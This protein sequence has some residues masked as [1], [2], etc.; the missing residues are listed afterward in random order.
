MPHK[1]IRTHSATLKV[2]IE[3]IT[4]KLETKLDPDEISY[5]QGAQGSMAYVEGWRMFN[6]A[7]KYLDSMVGVQKY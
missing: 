2:N 3:A 4:K 6:I 1:Y 7:M 5:R